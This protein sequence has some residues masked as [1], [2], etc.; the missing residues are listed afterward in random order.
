MLQMVDQK[1]KND[2]EIVELAI[3]R[4]PLAIQYLSK[5]FLMSNFAIAEKAVTLD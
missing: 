4:N 2:K 1:F 3:S 5:D